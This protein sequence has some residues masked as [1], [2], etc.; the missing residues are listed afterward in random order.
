MSLAP[1]EAVFPDTI[2]FPIVAVPEIPP[3]PVLGPAEI[4]FSFPTFAVFPV[5][6]LLI[7][8]NAAPEPVL[9]MPPPIAVSTTPIGGAKL[10]STPLELFPAKV[11]LI[12]VS[13]QEL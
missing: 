11:L 7:T 3:P 10:P 5:M 13:T 12:T 4:P 2:E 1:S 9:A 6:V 8:V